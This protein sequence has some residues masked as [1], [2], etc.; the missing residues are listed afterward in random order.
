MRLLYIHS[1]HVPSA[2]NA[3]QVA[4]MCTAFRGAGAEVLLALPAP[5]NS[6]DHYGMI[7]R[8]YGLDIEFPF[9]VLP[10]PFGLC[11]A[12]SFFLRRWRSLLL[13]GCGRMSFLHARLLWRL[14][15]PDFWIHDRF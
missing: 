14:F 6:Q 5:M 12:G 2:A 4:K 3:V 15:L 11:P 8:E 13:S 1:A 9:R 10:Y 7:A